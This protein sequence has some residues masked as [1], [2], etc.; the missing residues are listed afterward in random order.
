MDL[1]IKLMHLLEESFFKNRAA[2]DISTICLDD[3]VYYE[4][5]LAC[6][7]FIAGLLCEDCMVASIF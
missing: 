4:E 6:N 3:Q 5:Y 2:E 1:D 7:D